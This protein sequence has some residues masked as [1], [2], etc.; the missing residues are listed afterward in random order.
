MRRSACVPDVVE[1]L[2]R[3]LPEWFGIEESLNDYVEQARGLPT[4]TAN[5]DETA[6]GVVLVRQH[7]PGAAEIIL[8]AVD[9]ASTGAASVARCWHASRRTSSQRRSTCCR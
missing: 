6:A 9:R 2:L 3:G 5:V 8:M 1:T 4:Y 7:L